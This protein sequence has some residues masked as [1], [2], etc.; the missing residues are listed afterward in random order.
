MAEVSTTCE[1]DESTEREGVLMEP[2]G[3]DTS[4]AEAHLDQAAD[5]VSTSHID[6]SQEPGYPDATIE[7]I[8]KEADQSYTVRIVR[9]DSPSDE[10]GQ[11]EA[12]TSTMMMHTEGPDTS[13][14]EFDDVD[15][16]GMPPRAPRIAHMESDVHHMMAED[17]GDH[18]TVHVPSESMMEPPDHSTSVTSSS[19][20]ISHNSTSPVH[21]PRVV[22]TVEYI[23]SETIVVETQQLKLPTASTSVTSQSTLAQLVE[24]AS[25]SSPLITSKPVKQEEERKLASESLQHIMQLAGAGSAQPPTIK[26]I[27]PQNIIAQAPAGQ[28]LL[29][30]KYKELTSQATPSSGQVVPLILPEGLSMASSQPTVQ[31]LPQQVVAM[32][33]QSSSPRHTAPLAVAKSQIR[34]PQ[35][36]PGQQEIRISVPKT[37]LLSGSTTLASPPTGQAAQEIRLP[38]GGDLVLQPGEVISLPPQLAQGRFPPGATLTRTPSGQMVVT[39]M[40]SGG[41]APGSSVLGG[42]S[43]H[44]LG[45]TQPVEP[46]LVPRCLVCGDKS[47]GV[48]YGVLACEGCKVR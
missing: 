33:G 2:T 11:S 45:L 3:P 20:I 36:S 9:N 13:R 42:S 34:I 43:S 21:V 48:H 23:P 14:E 24:V 16:S 17:S 31:G 22:S 25:A 18:Y 44:G 28:S 7:V 47:S 29:T 12:D 5:A 38:S 15:G 27:L 8:N 4:A 39:H 32:A 37:S 35:L 46:R 41:V 6:E 10:T 19:Y 30:S 26:H 40:V 1:F